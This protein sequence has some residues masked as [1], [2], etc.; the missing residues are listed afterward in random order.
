[1]TQTPSRDWQKDMEMCEALEGEVWEALIDD[2]VIWRR[3]GVASTIWGK[4]QINY[5]QQHRLALPYWLQ[6]SKERGKREQRLKEGLEELLSVFKLHSKWAS[7]EDYYGSIYS[8]TD[9]DSEIVLR[10]HSLLAILYPDTQA[11]KEEG[12]NR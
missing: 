6:E 2:T 1:M 7:I 10:V 3:G 8:L 4:E 9:V 11:P 5:L 12:N